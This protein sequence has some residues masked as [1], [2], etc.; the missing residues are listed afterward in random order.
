MGTINKSFILL[1]V[2]FNARKMRTISTIILT[3]IVLTSFS[4]KTTEMFLTR[5]SQKSQFP[6][7]R[8][9]MLITFLKRGVTNSKILST[10][11]KFCQDKTFKIENNR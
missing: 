3:F 6:D 8:I 2:A 10:F 5:Q 4:Q 1:K 7:T 9:S 11:D